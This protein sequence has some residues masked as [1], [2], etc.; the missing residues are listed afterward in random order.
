MI[1]TVIRD[2]NTSVAAPGA[3]F[4]MAD[5]GFKNGQQGLERKLPRS[6]STLKNF[7]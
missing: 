7:C 1:G 4:K 3:K 2:I 5:R 6:L